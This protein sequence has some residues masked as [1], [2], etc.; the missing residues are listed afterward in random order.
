MSDID[1]IL[2]AV[3][4][5]RLVQIADEMD[6]TLYRSAFNPI[7]AE[8]H[9]ACHGLYHAQTGATLVQGTTGL[10][11]FVGAMAFAVKA[12]IDKANADGNLEAGDTYLFNDPYDGGTHLNDFRL[13]RPLFW[14]GKLFAWLASVG[15]WLDVGGNVPGNFNAKATESFQE[16]FRVPPVKLARAG[17]IQ[18]DIIDILAANSRV[19]QSNW[20]DLNGQLNA[21]D[22]G[23][24]RVQALLEDYGQELV[25]SALDLLTARA[26]K[27][28]RANIASLPDGAY[29][30]DDFL[31]NDG[32]TDVPLSIALD[33]VISGDT[34]R[35][36]FSR[37]SPPCDGPLNIALS[38]TVACC[39]VALKHI[40]TDVPANAGC[41]APIEFVIP[42]T[43]LL[44]VS[45]PRPVGG[46]TETILRVI[47]TVFGAFAK[48]APQR[49]NGSPFATINALSLSGWREHGRRWV[50]FCFFGG[51]LGGNPETDGL[52][53][54]NNPISTATIPPA[55]IL[56]SLYPVM[57]T[58]WAL[59]PD[60]GGPGFN[61]GGLGAIYEIEALA[62][63]ATD[64][65]L[66]GERGKFP[67]FGV[68][69]GRSAAL[70]RFVYQTDS[71][72]RA[73][74]LVS[75]VTDIRIVAGQHVRLETPGGGGFGDPMTRDPVRVGRDVNLG[76]VTKAAAR[77]DY[78]VVIGENGAVDT[79]A[80]AALRNGAGR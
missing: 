68:N 49:A 50:M 17:V 12:V 62:D 3:L 15:H 70:N 1:P 46:Y 31:D 60:S 42:N 4:N 29:S 45:A 10:P 25:A 76:Y 80:T 20:G 26:E 74:P 13:V 34:M 21:L 9:D 78:G 51:G 23:E 53:H 77:K 71:G 5:G 69:G 28:M 56:E 65:S 72:E 27:L 39:Y 55:E 7:I 75:K 8:A 6:A 44:A 16:G 2:L 52:N 79:A 48:V 66:L 24:R 59:R 61:R 38:T 18:Q 63:G 19:P 11:I 32:I 14:N 64:V 40:F 67:P 41:L 30:Y 37:S 43:T 73:P 36:D 58:Q 54:G 35:L 22:L 57:F 33:L 47:D